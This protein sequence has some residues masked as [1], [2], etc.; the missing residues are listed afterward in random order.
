MRNLLSSLILIFALTVSCSE[1][2]LESKTITNEPKEQKKEEF[3][4]Y[5]TTWEKSEGGV[6]I[7]FS[8]DEKKALMTNGSF[9]LRLS[10]SI[11][12]DKIT[13]T[14]EDDISSLAMMLAL[15]SNTAIADINYENGTPVSL[16]IHNKNKDAIYV[17]KK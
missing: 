15:G 11:F 14:S 5:G 17:L 13:L 4:F 6:E 7:M 16:T 9:N 2:A 12:N 3:S 10:Y 8:N 1:K